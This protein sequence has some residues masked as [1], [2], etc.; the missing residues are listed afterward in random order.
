MKKLMKALCIVS[1]RLVKDLC[2]NN[3]MVFGENK[4]WLNR[5]LSFVKREDAYLID[6]FSPHETCFINENS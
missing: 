3:K 2:R 6:V 1:V 4:D 5:E